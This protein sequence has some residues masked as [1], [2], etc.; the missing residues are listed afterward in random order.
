[1]VQTG[2]QILE[3][4][5]GYMAVAVGNVVHVIQQAGVLFVLARDLQDPEDTDVHVYTNGQE[6]L[7]GRLYA[8]ISCGFEIPAL[9]HTYRHRCQTFPHAGRSQRHEHAGSHARHVPRIL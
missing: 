1:M 3:G 6:G 2:R 4:L 7:S 5:D 8:K 9:Q